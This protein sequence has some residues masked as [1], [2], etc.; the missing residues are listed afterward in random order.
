MLWV[1][2]LNESQAVCGHTNLTYRIALSYPVCSGVHHG[3]AVRG[4]SALYRD[5]CNGD[6]NIPFP[7]AS[8]Y[9]L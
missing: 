1:K 8:S 6:I 4:V 7:A 5:R 2:A 9:T 3:R